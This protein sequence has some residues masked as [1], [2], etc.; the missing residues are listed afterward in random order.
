MHFRDR[1]AQNE[2]GFPF[3]AQKPA[4]SALGTV[5]M[6]HFGML[7]TQRKT[8]FTHTA[9]H[10]RLEPSPR[11]LASQATHHDTPSKLNATLA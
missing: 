8:C 5:M 7:P 4:S 6:G 10:P 1:K 2:T 9:L 11:N 3:I